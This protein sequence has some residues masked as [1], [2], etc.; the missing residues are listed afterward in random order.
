MSRQNDSAAL[1]ECLRTGNEPPGDVLITHPD[2]DAPPCTPSRSSND[3]GISNHRSAKTENG[4]GGT[5]SASVPVSPGPSANGSFFIGA[6]PIVEPTETHRLPT[7]SST[8][9][10]S[11][12][13]SAR[14]FSVSSMGLGSN[15]NA[16]AH[17]SF[18]WKVFARRSKSREAERRSD[19]TTHNARVSGSQSQRAS[20]TKKLEIIHVDHDKMKEPAENVGDTSDAEAEEKEGQGQQQSTPTLSFRSAPPFK[21]SGSTQAM[22]QTTTELSRSLSS[23]SS[24]SNSVR[25]HKNTLTN[26]RTVGIP[27]SQI[28][29]YDKNGP[30]R[31]TS[32]CSTQFSKGTI[33]GAAP[34]SHAA[35]QKSLRSTSPRQAIHQPKRQHKGNHQTR[36]PNS[37]T[38]PNHQSNM[39]DLIVVGTCK[40][41]YDFESSQ[42]GET[43]LSFKTGN[44]LKVISS[45]ARWHGSV[46]AD[47]WIYAETIPPNEGSR[48][49][50]Q[51]GFIPAGFVEITL[52]PEPLPLSPPRRHEPDEVAS[53][54]R[55]H[56]H[57]RGDNAYLA[58]GQATEL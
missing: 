35:H 37:E 34:T 28:S 1:I 13:R 6:D 44:K 4:D 23:P 30:F 46:D 20:P 3:H 9:Y 47:G 27:G 14:R 12:S 50:P 32:P 58:L 40:A 25:G 10:P 7:L 29:G 55:I 17:S 15:G 33:V 42:Y 16:G 5:Y 24:S 31:N 8:S 43:F 22:A 18:L 51:R 52:Y 21:S 19:A 57:A 49:H 45:A 38:K 39:S 2:I 26:P 54:R 11:L 53:H 48:S 36:K 56:G 41:L